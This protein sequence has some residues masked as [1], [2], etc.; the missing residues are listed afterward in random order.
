MKQTVFVVEDD[1]DI[2]ELLHFNLDREGFLVKLESH[3]D[4]A[5]DRI[6]KDPPVIIPNIKVHE[7]QNDCRGNKRQKEDFT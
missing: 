7:Q 3:G 5:F 1:P 6:I 4:K 2:A